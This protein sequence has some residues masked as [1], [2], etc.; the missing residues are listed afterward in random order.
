MY[1]FG[2]IAIEKLWRFDLKL[3]IHVVISAAHVH[4]QRYLYFCLGSYPNISTC[5]FNV[6]LSKA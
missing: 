6:Q 3:R 5:L 1:S 2:D 4:S